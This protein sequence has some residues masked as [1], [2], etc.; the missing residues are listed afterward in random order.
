MLVALLG[1]TPHAIAS[2][3]SAG[4]ILVEAP[5]A[6]IVAD[7]AQRAQRVAMVCALRHHGAC[8]PAL[9]VSAGHK[10]HDVA[11]LLAYHGE[12][13]APAPQFLQWHPQLQ[14]MHKL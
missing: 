10:L 12:V 5:A 7:G 6:A 2:R 8:R 4:R 14:V 3:V 11:W 1:L 13:N 9:V